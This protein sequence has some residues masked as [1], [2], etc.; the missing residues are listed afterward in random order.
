MVY[1]IQVYK[2]L[3]FRAGLKNPR[4]RN[5][6]FLLRRSQGKIFAYNLIL[7]KLVQIYPLKKHSLYKPLALC[8][9]FKSILR[10][11]IWSKIKDVASKAQLSNNLDQN[12]ADHKRDI[13]NRKNLGL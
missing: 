13:I 12:G 2:F 11:I 5:K 9:Y 10:L 4:S 1:T 6:F 3:N 7:N 8:I